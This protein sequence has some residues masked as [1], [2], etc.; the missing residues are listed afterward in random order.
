MNPARVDKFR[1]AAKYTQPTLGVILE[2]ISDTHNIGAIMR[3]CDSVGVR[4]I[5]IVNTLDSGLK[6]EIILGKRSSM[7]TRKWV[8]TS[9]YR[10]WE[11]C[12]KAVRNHH[13]TIYGAMISS[14]TK[15]IYEVDWT[16]NICIVLGNEMSGL[17]PE[18]M[19]Q[20]D[21]FISIP[22]VGMAE[23]LNVSVAAAVILFEAFR[24]RQLIGKYSFA[25]DISESES[26]KLFEHFMKKSDDRTRDQNHYKISPK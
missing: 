11:E 20:C 12:I 7:G 5:Y 13:E 14:D 2:N 1:R 18:A 16:C 4:K 23:S 8:E 6:E 15:E 22:Q 3:T 9:Y 19:I 24:Q 21:G 10:D 17:T 25:P 26:Q